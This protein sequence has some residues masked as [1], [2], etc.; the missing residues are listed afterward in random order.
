VSSQYPLFVRVAISKL[1]YNIGEMIAV[2]L[3]CINPNIIWWR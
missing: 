2:K 3:N 1:L